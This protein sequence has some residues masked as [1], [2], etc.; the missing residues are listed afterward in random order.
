MKKNAREESLGTRLKGYERDFET[1][2]DA[3]SFIICRIDGH[4]FSKYTKG[5]MKP[6]DAILSNTMVKTSEALIE[7][8][9]AVTT[10]TQSDEITMI[11]APQYKEKLKPLESFLDIQVPYGICE[12]ETIPEYR[13]FDREDN[14]IGTVSTDFDEDEEGYCITTY[15]ISGVDG[16]VIDSCVDQGR[17]PQTRVKTAAMFAKYLI[18][19]VEIINEQIFG[20]RIQKMASLIASFTTMKFNK[21]FN[22]G[23]NDLVGYS[24]YT[25]TDERKYLDLML[26]KVGKAWFDARL[27]GVPSKE[28]AYN[29]VLWRI[30]DAEK[31]SRSMFAQTYCSHKSL[32]KKNGLEQVEFCKETTGKDW[33]DVEDGYKYGFLTKRETYEKVVNLDDIQVFSDVSS[34]TRK[35]TVTWAEALTTFSEEKVDMIVR[36]LK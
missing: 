23:I 36:K 15:Y 11:F 21:Y 20:G 18:K 34:I 19:E 17:N 16:E 4:K 13:I 28:E 10:Y 7:K 8:F 26:S 9:G 1:R 12:V 27:Y 29:S 3:K 6:F 32:L 35:R 22:D 2:I 24:E 25:T 31:N 14:Y 33:N 5:M 30:R